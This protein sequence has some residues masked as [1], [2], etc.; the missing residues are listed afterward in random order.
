MY[1][2]SYVTI[3]VA[4]LRFSSAVFTVLFSSSMSLMLHPTLTRPKSHI[5]PYATLGMKKL[6]HSTAA[7]PSS[8]SDLSSM[9]LCYFM[10]ND[11]R[12][13]VAIKA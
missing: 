3:P 11:R 1:S 5:S 4:D 10:T 7:L 12:L 2:I 13:Y 8:G 9:Y 6:M